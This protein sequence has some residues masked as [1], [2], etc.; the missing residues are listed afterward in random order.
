MVIVGS[1]GLGKLQGYVAG[2]SPF[3]CAREALLMIYA[4]CSKYPL[5]IDLA[6][7]RAKEQRASHGQSSLSNLVAYHRTLKLSVHLNAGRPSSTQE[8]LAKD[9]P[10]SFASRSSCLARRCLYRKECLDETRGR[11]PRR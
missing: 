3:V 10:G 11:D 6:L 9:R 1:R 8:T 4:F 2:G 7:P 5:G